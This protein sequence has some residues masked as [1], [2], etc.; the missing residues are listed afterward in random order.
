[1]IERL[2]AYVSDGNVE[3]A[4]HAATALATM[5]NADLVLA[6]S[7][8]EWTDDLALNS[9]SLLARLASLSQIALYSP[10]LIHPHCGSLIRFVETNLLR[11]KTKQVNTCSIKLFHGIDNNV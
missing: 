3:Q 11:S 6:D 5:K 8:I 7:I 9:A 2:I 4:T 1:L 10:T